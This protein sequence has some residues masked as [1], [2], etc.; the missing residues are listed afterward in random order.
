[1]ML[2]WDLESPVTFHADHTV[3]EFD[4]RFQAEDLGL[5]PMGRTFRWKMLG[6]LSGKD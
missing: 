6:E 1:M 2:D 3:H 5:V 4:Q